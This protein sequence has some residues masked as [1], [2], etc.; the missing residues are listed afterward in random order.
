MEK[1]C[2]NHRVEMV[3][4]QLSRSVTFRGDDIAVAYEASV[5]PE[6]GLESVAVD[7]A[8]R[9]QCFISDCYRKQHGLLTGKKIKEL[10]ESQGVTQARLAEAIHVGIASIKRWENGLVQNK[11]MDELLRDFL[12]RGN[13]GLDPHGMRR[14]ICAIGENGGVFLPVQVLERL[15]LTAGSEVD[16]HLDEELG[17][18]VITPVQRIE[19]PED[20]D[21][22]FPDRVNEVSEPFHTPGKKQRNGP[23]E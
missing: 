1:L 20:S 3:V 11:A 12:E 17:R 21:A 8:H 6:C 5:C 15:K 19:L 18:I 10:R 23:R 9:M 14:K 16:V 7:V 2:P 4:K 22:K 13:R